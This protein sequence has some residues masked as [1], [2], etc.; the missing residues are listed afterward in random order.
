MKLPGRFIDEIAK[1]AGDVYSTMSLVQPTPP[2]PEPAPTMTSTS[3]ERAGATSISGSIQSQ[4][5]KTAEAAFAAAQYLAS[6][7]LI[8]S[9]GTARCGAASTTQNACYDR[10]ER[11]AGAARG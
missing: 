3:R 7:K 1:N 6:L 9:N 10:R 11:L 5:P 2:K 4:T 8:Y